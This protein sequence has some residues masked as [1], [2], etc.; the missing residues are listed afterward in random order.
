MYERITTTNGKHHA[1]TFRLD[2]T[3]LNLSQK[4][5]LF[6]S[7]LLSHLKCANE[8]KKMNFVTINVKRIICLQFP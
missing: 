5:F 8:I 1:I 6:I 7:L 4:K 3:G 2:W